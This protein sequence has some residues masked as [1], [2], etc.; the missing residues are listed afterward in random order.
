MNKIKNILICGLGGVGCVCASSIYN[1]KMFNLKILVDEK[2]IE[3]Y[4]QTPT[5]YNG[6]EYKFNYILPSDN[7]F[8]AD[9]IIIATK[10]DGLK[11]AIKNIKNFINENTIIVSLLNGIHSEEEIARVY[12]WKNVLISF[13]IGNSCIRENRNITMKGNYNIVI[14]TNREENKEALQKLKVLF[15]EAKINYKSEEKI[16]DEYWKK[17]IINVGVNQACAYTGL[18]LKEIRENEKHTNLLKNLMIEAREIAKKEGIINSKNIYIEAENFLLKELD[19]AHPSMLQDV[20]NKR[21]SE[22]EIFAGKVLEFGKKH[23]IKTPSN[24]KIFNTIKQAENDYL[25]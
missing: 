5:T 1:A 16:L 11:K 4:K 22:V 2:R 21:K 13:Y 25:L 14:G 7:D 17:F 9:L 3:N 8:K 6:K 23:N 12:G 24:E 20:E 18:E 15:K 19:N 10:N